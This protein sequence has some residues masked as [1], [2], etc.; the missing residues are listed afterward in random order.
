M[1]V[2]READLYRK[3]GELNLA[4]ALKCKSKKTG[5]L[6]GNYEEKE[7]RET[8]PLLENFC[9]VLSLF[10]SRLTEHVLEAKLLLDKLLSFEVEGNFP[11]Y[12][13]EYPLCKD[14]TLGLEILPVLHFLLQDFAP[15]LG[16]CVSRLETLRSRVLAHANK[17]H[18]ERPLPAALEVRLRASCKNW[19]PKT[20]EEWAHGLITYQMGMAL[21]EFLHRAL[22]KWD[23]SLCLYLGEQ[24]QRGEEPEVTLLDLFCGHYY[25]HYSKRALQPHPSHLRAALIQPFPQEAPSLSSAIQ[26]QLSSPLVLHWG[27]SEKLHS[28]C[29]EVRKNALIKQEGELQWEVALPPKEDNG[30]QE[31]IELAFFVNVEAFP[32]FKVCAKKAS[33]FQLGDPIEFSSAG[34]SFTLT[35]TFEEGEGKFFGHLLRGNRAAQREKEPLY[36]TYDAQV[37]LRSIYRTQSCRFKVQLLYKYKEKKV[38]TQLPLLR[39][40]VAE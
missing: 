5:Y 27:S 20:P 28:F 22:Q 25:S 39:E 21:D 35:V 16:E 32:T 23:P 38:T 19:E 6:H 13:H 29:I 34:F 10:R 17:M 33:T 8:I 14:R 31:E 37:A 3:M 1:G 18:A 26:L 7:C 15:L 30:N 4:A 11:L 36:A 12:L 9:Y 24:S 40:G 2:E